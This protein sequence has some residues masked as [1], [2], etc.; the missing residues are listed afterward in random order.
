MEVFR[1]GRLRRAR[2]QAVTLWHAV[3]AGRARAKATSP[4]PQVD[5]NALGSL[6]AEAGAEARLVEVPANRRPWTATGLRVAGGEHVTWLAWGRAYLIKPLALGVGPSV[7]LLGRVGDGRPQESSRN[8]L[9]FPADRDGLLELAGRL[10]GE[11]QE[12]GSIAMDR[13]PYRAMR[14]GFAAAVARWPAGADVRAAL[15]ALA[16]RDPSGLCAAEAARLA[17]PPKAPS[18]WEYHP[19]AGR[20]EVFAASA[21]GVVADCPDSV[22]LIRRPAAAPLTPTLR[23]RWS[24]RLDELPST[25]PEDTAFTH[26]YLSVALEFDDGQDLT[27]QWSCELPEGFAYRCPLEHWR[28]RE[29]HVVVRRGTADLGEWVEDERPV[30]ADH[31]AAIGGP[32][33][34]SVVRAWLIS[35]SLNQ[36]GTAR[37]EFGHIDL[38]DGTDVV[39]VL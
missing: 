10:P 18:G 1:E 37:G 3:R 22:G 33:P 2:R 36:G 17:Q 19:L 26:D 30:L 15:E 39:R 7:G 38:V 12:D 9:T 5:G 21:D 24:W 16:P 20:E 29:T 28:H 31:Q 35:V 25:L 27:W 13:V 34:T 32:A 6:L 4:P 23:L 8:S 14:G 11:L